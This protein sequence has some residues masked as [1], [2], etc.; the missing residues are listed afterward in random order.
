[1]PTLMLKPGWTGGVFRRTVQTG[2]R[3]PKLLTF[4]KGEPVEVS[5]D[6]YLALNEVGTVLFDVE[7]DEKGRH[8]FVEPNGAELEVV[9]SV[10]DSSG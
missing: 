2:K 8:R 9:G 1:M 7:P 10:S 5:D 3:K 4:A 6:E